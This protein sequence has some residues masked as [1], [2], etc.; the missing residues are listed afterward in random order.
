[1]FDVVK[2]SHQAAFLG[3]KG[4]E[5]DAPRQFL[6][7]LGQDPRDL[8][9][10]RR[11]RRVVVCAVEHHRLLALEPHS[12]VIVMGADDDDFIGP[13]SLAFEHGDDVFHL[14]R[15]PHGF[16]LGLGRLANLAPR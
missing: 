9:H 1:M 7:P 16:W 14:D 6:F 13:R 8:E 11:S 5:Q 12:Q 15:L 10:G 4:D 3:G 2:T